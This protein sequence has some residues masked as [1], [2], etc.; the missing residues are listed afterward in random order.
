MRYMPITKVAEGMI[1]GQRICNGEGK[2]LLEQEAKLQREDVQRLFQMGLPGIYVE[3]D[4]SWDLKIP[5]LISRELER[6]ALELVHRLF[7]EEDFREIEQEDIQETARKMTRQILAGRDKMYQTVNVR[8]ADD[9]TFFHS[10]N[11]AALSVMLGVKTGNLDLEQL[12]KLAAAALLHDVGKRYVE[13]DVLNAKRS[14]TEE[15]RVLVVQHPKLSYDF[16]T[17]HYHFSQEV[18]DGVLEHHEWYNGCGYPMRRSGYEISYFAR[19]IKV[20]D[21]FDALTSKLPYHD[22]IS[23]SGAVDYILGNTESEFDPDL[24]ELFTSNIAVYP[25]GC[26]VMLS[27]GRTALVAENDPEH[28]LR[29]KVI[30]IPDGEMINLKSEKDLAVLELFV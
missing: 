14:L 27:D 28:M 29:P 9:Y 20:A 12:N 7:E 6:E 1:L 18:C 15:E 17:E 10:V 23:P 21:V 16:L 26:E 24:A 25:A 3:D 11:V 5:R 2:I 4:I 30:T 19:I 13:A 22:P 8:V